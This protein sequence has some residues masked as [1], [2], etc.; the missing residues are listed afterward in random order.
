MGNQASIF[1]ILPFYEGLRFSRGFKV[2]LHL[3]KAVF[4]DDMCL[5][6]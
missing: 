5:H 3:K 1:G 6:T 4:K 2:N